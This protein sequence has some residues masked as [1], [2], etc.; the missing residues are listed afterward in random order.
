MHTRD[1]AGVTF[2]N[3]PIIGQTLPG[4]VFPHFVFGCYV[5]V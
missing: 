2:L 4:F 5:S 3:E 1:S